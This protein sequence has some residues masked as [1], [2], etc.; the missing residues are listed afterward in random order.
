MWNLNHVGTNDDCKAP[1]TEAMLRMTSGASLRKKMLTQNMDMKKQSVKQ[2]R[3]P[4][5]GITWRFSRLELDECGDG[6]SRQ[7]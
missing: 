1:G 5:L 4:Q 7:C 2:K 6:G 3:M